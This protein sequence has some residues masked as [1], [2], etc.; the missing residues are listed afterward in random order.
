MPCHILHL[1]RFLLTFKPLR[2]SQILILELNAF[3]EMFVLD[4]IPVETLKSQQKPFLSIIY[5]SDS[6]LRGDFRLLEINLDEA[7]MTSRGA[8]RPVE[9]LQM[10]WIPLYL[11]S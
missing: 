7:F 2:S 4:K 3:D 1:T 9:T 10:T 5:L 11:Y 8:H 6:A